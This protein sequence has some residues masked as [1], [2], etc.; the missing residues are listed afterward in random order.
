VTDTITLKGLVVHAR[1]GVLEHE[2]THP[3]P[4]VIDVTVHLDTR[5]AATHD[6]LEATVDYGALAARIHDVVEAESWALIERVAQRV[7]DV[8]LDSPLCEAVDVTVHKPH[9][10]IGLAFEDVAVRISRSR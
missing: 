3:Q 2:Q 6:R 1:H 5:D 4:F 7:A 9:A 10:P 8:V